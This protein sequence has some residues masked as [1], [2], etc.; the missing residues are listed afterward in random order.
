MKK[1]NKKIFI[2]LGPT[3]SGKTSLGLDLCKKFNGEIISA[4]SRQVFKFM[5]VGTGK[6]PVN[7]KVEIERGDKFWLLDGIKVWGYDLVTPD[8]YFSGYDFAEFA[9]KKAKEIYD[10]GKTM[11]LVGGTGFYID[12]FTG[13]VQPSKVLPDLEL[14]TS[15]EELSLSDLQRKLQ[16]L[17][18]GAFEEIDKKNKV[19][20]VRAIEKSLSKNI[21][22]KELSYLRD[23]EF[24]HIGLNTPREVLYK[25][26]DLWVEYIWKNNIVGEVNRLCDLGYGESPKI[27]GLVYKTV[28]EYIRGGINEN[29]AIERIKFDIHAYVRRQLTWFK[30]NEE[31]DWVDIT[32]DD[33]REIIYNKVEEKIKNG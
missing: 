14:R 17:D 8:Q 13:K 20:L 21:N 18:R 33:F 30:K 6:I 31:I 16:S 23:F 27:K 12:L 4:D 2:I 3:S 24:V 7:S 11:F 28:L 19:R 22:D 5:D 1:E 25:R 15:L 10:S 26:S 32:K 29:E 9:L